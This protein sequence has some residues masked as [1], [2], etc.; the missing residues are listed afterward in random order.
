MRPNLFNYATRELS[1]DAFLAWYFQWADSSVTED[2][3]LQKSAREFLRTYI[4][5]VYTDYDIPI[6]HVEVRSQ[7]KRID[8]LI[9]VN[10]EITIIV[11]DKIYAGVHGK[12]LEK[13]WDSI[14]GKKIGLYIK[15]G[16]ESSKRVKEVENRNYIY[17]GRSVLLNHLSKCKSQNEI[18]VSFKSYWEKIEQKMLSFKDNYCWEVGQVVGFYQELQKNLNQSDWHYASNPNGGDWVFNWH[19]ITINDHNMYLEFSFPSKCAGK[20]DI[21]NDFKL[22]VKIHLL[23][24]NRKESRPAKDILQEQRKSVK[25]S[26]LYRFD[27]YANGLTRRPQKTH[28]GSYMTIAEV[29]FLK[30]IDNDLEHW[31]ISKL[32]SKLKEYETL[33]NNYQKSIMI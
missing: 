7:E 8:V 13:Y 11:E 17:V 28:I 26:H 5:K 15:T 25:Q 30:L 33:L 18:F 23:C 2:P 20:K 21:F 1:Q 19:W 32:V 3:D 9:V 29:S 12:Q 16:E 6:T 14:K 10:N 4:R 27:K 22:K 31:S 24:E